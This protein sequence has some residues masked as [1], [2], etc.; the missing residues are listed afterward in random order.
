M[1]LIG[2]FTIGQ[3]L[4]CPLVNGDN[5]G[6]EDCDIDEL[7]DVEQTLLSLCEGSPYIIDVVDGS[8]DFRRP[9]L[10]DKSLLNSVVTIRVF[11]S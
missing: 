7:N 5:S 9:D 11:A 2:E 3:H 6:L 4:I 1:E 8:E 10:G